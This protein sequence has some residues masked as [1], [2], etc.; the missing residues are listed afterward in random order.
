MQFY[1]EKKSITL[2][3]DWQDLIGTML[4]FVT[5]A[6]IQNDTEQQPKTEEL[7]RVGWALP[8]EAQTLDN[9][10][11]QTEGMRAL[12][13][14]GNGG[15]P[16]VRHLDDVANSSVVQYDIYVKLTNLLGG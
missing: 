16:Q 2:L 14:A 8:V 3:R 4:G 15:S 1:S 7:H 9:I 13:K 6:D 5:G 11:E 12:I 10:L